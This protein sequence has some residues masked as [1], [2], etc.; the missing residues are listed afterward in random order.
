MKKLVCLLLILGFYATSATAQKFNISFDY[1]NAELIMAAL[2]STHPLNEKLETEIRTNEDVKTVIN[3][4]KRSWPAINMDTLVKD[5]NT[6]N[7]GEKI[8]REDY[9]RLAFVKKY[10]NRND[11]LLNQIKT[12]ADR[13]KTELSNKL[14]PWMLNTKDELTVKVHFILLG[15]SAGFAIN[16]NNFY[17]GLHWKEGDIT[18]V[19]MTMHHELFHSLQYKYYNNSNQLKEIEKFDERE[20]KLYAYFTSL[21]KEGTAN[22]IAD[23]NNYSSTYTKQHFIKQQQ[24]LNVMADSFLLF[25]TIVY[26]F[27]NDPSFK[28]MNL[29]YNIGLGWDW[30]N[31]GYHMGYRMSQLIEKHKGTERLKDLLGKDPLY[32]L[33]DY[34]AIMRS[35]KSDSSIVKLSD[36]T[37]EIIEKM[38]TK[39]N[40]QD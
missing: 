37:V 17:I 22:Y 13:L 38:I 34:L 19:R 7:K 1:S 9:F 6:L 5:I 4:F 15:A 21:Y 12:S 28:N 40:L 8:T 36:S 10:I 2:K 14:N 39:L 23:V 30:N 24:G 26:R 3:K 31:P 29:I 16:A 35:N 20:Q 25:E 27:Y 33:R 18:G 32:F 11:S